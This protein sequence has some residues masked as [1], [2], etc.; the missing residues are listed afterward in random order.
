MLLF[1]LLCLRHKSAMNQT[2]LFWF[3]SCGQSV[4]NTEFVWSF[5][6]VSSKSVCLVWR[7]WTHC[8][9]PLGVMMT[10]SPAQDLVSTWLEECNK[11]SVSLQ[12]VK[13]S[14]CLGR[15]GVLLWVCFGSV[16]V[17]PVNISCAAL[18]LWLHFS[19][20][21]KPCSVSGVSET[22]RELCVSPLDHSRVWGCSD[23]AV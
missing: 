14:W 18:I 22:G 5:C 2:I 17:C 15:P 4:K 1:I 6:W 3:L 16:S 12:T 8:F 7:F 13:P 11:I 9:D 19:V 21:E 20:G 10:W 23:C